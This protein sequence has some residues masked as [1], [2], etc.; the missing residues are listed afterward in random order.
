[1]WL[2]PGLKNASA[3]TLNG[4]ARIHALVD[5]QV[6]ILTVQLT[7]RDSH[8]RFNSAFLGSLVARKF[9]QAWHTRLGTDGVLEILF[10]LKV[11]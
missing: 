11:S 4:M 8:I 1:M 5:G 9:R 6:T 2:T 3:V 10:P 7:S